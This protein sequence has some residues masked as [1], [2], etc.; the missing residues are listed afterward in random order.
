MRRRTWLLALMGAALLP[1]AGWAGQAAEAPAPLTLEECYR[2]ALKRSEEIAIH[3]ELINE[4]EGRFVQALGTALPRAS[5]SLSEKRQDG[6]GGSS[7]TLKEVPERKFVFTQPLFAGFKE[8]AAM[9]ASRAEHRQRQFEKS[10]AELTLMVNVSDAFYLLLEQRQDRQALE[11]VREALRARLQELD[12]RAR[13][14]RSRASELASAE[15][16]LRRVEAQMEEAKRDEATGEHLL[17]FLTGLPRIG[18]L[19]D[20][21][22]GT[23]VLNTEDAYLARVDQRPDVHAIEQA[24]HVAEKQVSIARAKFF[25]TVD[26]EANYYTKHV[27]TASGVDWDAALLVKVP[28]F[29]GGQALGAAKEAAAKAREAKLRYEETQRAAELDIRDAYVKAATALL[30]VQMLEQALQ[31]A[32]ESY[33]LQVEDY[34]FNLVSNLDVLQELEALEAVRRDRIAAYYE[35]RRFYRVLQA[36]V[37]E[38]L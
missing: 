19:Q 10:K 3:Q 20:I 27:G 21:P 32:E 5:F 15:A 34:R 30:R 9:G 18:E 38:R 36:S 29:Q 11:T 13:L 6:S 4:T 16:K 28:I 23:L 1:H 12:E 35:A 24:W 22:D 37:G 31:A 8:F 7:F 33:R 14:G 26:A 17:A 2:L 25:P